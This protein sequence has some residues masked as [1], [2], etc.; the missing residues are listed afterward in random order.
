MHRPSGTWTYF[1][2][3]LTLAAL[4]ILAACGQTT[5]VSTGGSPHSSLSNVPVGIGNNPEPGTNGQ[6]Q[7]APHGH[8]DSIIAVGNVAYVGSDNGRLYALEAGK[9]H[10]EW[11]RSLGA[12]VY[13][14][15]VTGGAVYVTSD[16]SSS[17]VLYAVDTGTGR[18]LWQF[19]PD[20]SITKVVAS[21]GMIIACASSS[22]NTMT[23]YGLQGA[24]GTPVWHYS[25]STS[26]PRLLG[27]ADGNVYVNQVMGLPSSSTSPSALYTLDAATGNVLW[28]ATLSGSD[29]MAAGIPVE[30]SG[31]VYLESG[32]G[33]V[34]A[35]QAA[36][37]AVVWHTSGSQVTG[38]P[39]TVLAP[40]SPL[41]ANGLVYAGGPMGV[42]A[43]RAGDGSVVWHFQ[44]SLAGPILPQLVLVSGVIYVEGFQLVA[45]LSATNGAVLWQ[46]QDEGSGEPLSGP[47]FVSNGMVINSGTAVFALRASDGTQLWTS[48]ITPDGVGNMNAGSQESLAGGVIY[49]GTDD[50]VVHAVSAG[51]GGVLWTYAI[52]ELL[53]PT[54][55]V[56]SALV[57]FSSSTTYQQALQ[58]VTNLGLQTSVICTEGWADS[59][60]SSA[61]SQSH[62]LLVQST[63]ASAPLWM[64]RLLSTPGVENAQSADG[65]VNCPMI[66]VTNPPPPSY[67]GSQEAGKF[68]RVTFASSIPYADALEGVDGLGFRL[69]DP[70]YEQARA[71]GK[72]PTWHLMSQEAPY[73]ASPGLL[74]AITTW[75]STT[76]QTQVRA[77]PGVTAVSAPYTVA[78]QTC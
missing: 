74:L 62:T 13:V 72:K 21:N 18:V 24:T 30:T 60:T 55:P 77:L 73:E 64:S 14:F 46:H 47:P 5:S 17:S 48:T 71:Q 6:P 42:T 37:G 54:P 11:Q 69:A 50:G 34:Y 22:G 12:S 59:D 65:A 75:N 16:S 26:L 29:G 1:L 51:S 63:V 10:V 76:W 44:K 25:L 67:L 15:A 57:N 52:P 2:L 78:A 70:C 3:A 38:V 19:R 9:W 68:I 33:G 27:A 4:V 7:P 39:P 28:H 31:V 20:T 53:V 36:T 8:G 56:F 40:D 58:M 49:L 66:P 32:N 45:A 41:I 23:L 61:F 35:L 43:Y